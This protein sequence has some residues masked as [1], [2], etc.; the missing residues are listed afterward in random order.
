MTVLLHRPGRASA[1]H[2]REA[3]RLLGGALGEE[4]HSR[5]G[6]PG[7]GTTWTLL[8]GSDLVRGPAPPRDR[9]VVFPRLDPRW[10]LEDLSKRPLPRIPAG[11]SVVVPPGLGE[12]LLGRARPDLLPLRAGSFP[13]PEETPV[14]A[15]GPYDGRPAGD[16]LDPGA[17]LPAPGTGL[18]AL[19]APA[20]VPPAVRALEDADARTAL[21][22]ERAFV[23]GVGDLPEGGAL[24][25]LSGKKVSV[26][27]EV[28]ATLFLPGAPP[29]DLK[30]DI[31]LADAPAFAI[32][33]GRHLRG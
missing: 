3:A 20:E 13:A 10:S 32:R 14:L 19:L 16:P 29:R 31:P 8:P 6:A 25:A 21:A 2:A 23:A 4:V 22:I 28:W 11:A 15:E 17:F 7:D 9:L 24:G 26:L 5:V 30:A 27:F 12:A 18:L 33:F 1:L